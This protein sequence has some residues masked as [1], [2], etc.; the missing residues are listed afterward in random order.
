[1]HGQDSSSGPVQ[2]CVAVRT[3][4]MAAVAELQRGG[5]PRPIAAIG[6]VKWAVVRAR[7]SPRTSPAVIHTQGR[8]MD[9][10]RMVVQGR[11]VCRS[12]S[13]S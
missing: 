8:R 5:D 11:P 4:E 10:S 13:A 7:E 2:T 1:M 12:A 6:G 3:G 9:D